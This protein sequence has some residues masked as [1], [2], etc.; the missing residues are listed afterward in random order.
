M[1]LSL[2]TQKLDSKKFQYRV[3]HNSRNTFSKSVDTTKSELNRGFISKDFQN[4]IEDLWKYIRV[5]FDKKK[6]EGIIPE[7]KRFMKKIS[8]KHSKDKDGKKIS[9][10]VETSIVREF[11]IQIG[12]ENKHF[13]DEKSLESYRKIQDFIAK[14]YKLSVLRSDLHLD[15]TVPHIHFLATTYNFQTGEFSKE[16]N[17]LYSYEKMQKEVFG[18][19]QNKLGIDLESYEKKECFGDD[20]I[21]PAVYNREKETIKKAK[22]FCLEKDDLEASRNKLAELLKRA[23][24]FIIARNEKIKE[25]ENDNENLKARLKELME[26][27]EGINQLTEQDSVGNFIEFGDGQKV[28]KADL[29]DLA[30]LEDTY[31]FFKE[32]TFKEYLQ[33][34]EGMFDSGINKLENQNE[35]NQRQQNNLSSLGAN[36]VR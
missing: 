14:K 31:P 5:D 26:V 27:K 33:V 7:K 6:L 11:I 23:K 28:E 17:S 13:S 10:V 34:M 12:N 36:I 22:K 21:S 19:C 30:T 29:A 25:L 1:K 16:F 3:E 20:Y 8:T 24:V 35:I 9:T 15:E 2:R 18:F 32:M 4:S